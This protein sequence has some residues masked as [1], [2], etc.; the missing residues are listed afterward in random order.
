VQS[1]TCNLRAC[2]SYY[3][4]KKG[5]CVLQPGVHMITQGPLGIQYNGLS[6]NTFLVITSFDGMKATISGEFQP[7]NSR[8]MTIDESTATL[9]IDSIIIANFKQGG[10]STNSGTLLMNLGYLYVTNSKFYNNEGWSCPAIL[11]DNKGITTTSNII[12]SDSEFDNNKAINGDWTNNACNRHGS[13]CLYGGLESNY[14]SML[15]YLITNVTFNNNEGCGGSEAFTIHLGNDAQ[16]GNCYAINCMRCYGNGYYSS[17]PCYTQLCNQHDNAPSSSLL[18]SLCP[19]ERPSSPTPSPNVEPTQM[20]TEVSLLSSRIVV[21]GGG[22]SK[23]YIQIY[24]III[25]N[26]VVEV[27]V[28][29]EVPLVEMQV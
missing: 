1:S 22:I 5:T 7:Y 3:Q 14:G 19:I 29:V 13:I 23:F 12:I 4:G 16:Y 15:Q 28:H 17:I 21:A 24:I 27:Q 10:D 11:Y 2:I 9:H 8:L 20:P 18:A 26:Q 6:P 25:I